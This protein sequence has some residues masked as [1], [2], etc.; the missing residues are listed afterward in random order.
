MWASD[1]VTVVN[2]LVQRF[3]DEQALIDW[4]YLHGSA[5]QELK[6]ANSLQGQA[7]A[8]VRHVESL[9]PGALASFAAGIEATTGQEELK[10]A[11]L[12]VLRRRLVRA[13]TMDDL[14]QRL[15]QWCL[16]WSPPV[17]AL[18]LF[19]VAVMVPGY[20]LQQRDRE[21]ILAPCTTYAKVGG[22][23]RACMKLLKTERG[24]VTIAGGVV[25]LA[26]S[27]DVLFADRGEFFR[28]AKL[29]DPDVELPDWETHPSVR[30]QFDATVVED[31][32]P[33]AEEALIVMGPIEGGALDD[34]MK[35]V[36]DVPIV[37][38]ADSMNLDARLGS[39]VL[40]SILLDA[41][42]AR[43]VLSKSGR[44]WSAFARASS[45]EPIIDMR[46]PPLRG[47]ET[48]VPSQVGEHINQAKALDAAAASARKGD[49][50]ASARDI[51]LARKS[52]GGD[53][54]IAAIIELSDELVALA[55]GR[56][57][58]AVEALK[59][60]QASE[61]PEAV[62]AHALGSLAWKQ[63]AGWS[64]S[65]DA[66]LYIP[67]SD[68]VERQRLLDKLSKERRDR[69]DS[70]SSA[71]DALVQ[72]RQEGTARLLPPTDATS[73]IEAK[74]DLNDK[75]LATLTTLA[76]E[77]ESVPEQVTRAIGLLREEGWHD[78]EL[79][80]T[81]AYV[82]VAPGTVAKDDLKDVFERVLRPE[83]G[84][85][86]STTS[87]ILFPAMV[88]RQERVLDASEWDAVLSRVIPS[89]T[90]TTK[91]ELKYAST[92]RLAMRLAMWLSVSQVAGKN[93]QLHKD[94]LDGLALSALNEGTWSTAKIG[95][96]LGT[97]LY[98][99]PA[100]TNFSGPGDVEQLM[101]WLEQF[102]S[103]Y[104]EQHPM[105]S[106]IANVILAFGDLVN[107]RV[108]ESHNR[109]AKALPVLR[110]GIPQDT[111]DRIWAI[112][113]ATTYLDAYVLAL[114]QQ[115]DEARRRL[116]EAKT[117]LDDKID[118]TEWSA[119]EEAKNYR[120]ANSSVHEMLGVIV[121]V[122][123]H[124]LT[125][126]AAFE[127]LVA[128]ANQT[129]FT[130]PA[131]G[132]VPELLLAGRVGVGYAIVLAA[133]LLG[134][135]D[136]PGALPLLQR[137]N[138]DLERV[139]GVFGAHGATAH[140]VVQRVVAL[141][142]L[143]TA[144]HLD[145]KLLDDLVEGAHL[146][147]TDIAPASLAANYS[148]D[149]DRFEGL[150]LYVMRLVADVYRERYFG[151]IEPDDVATIIRRRC[152]GAIEESFAAFGSHGLLG[153]A[154]QVTKANLHA[155]EG[156]AMA[157]RAAFSDASKTTI[158]N[159][160][161]LI[162]LMRTD[163][164]AS[165]GEDSGRALQV[166]DE[167]LERN[168]QWAA[169]LLV[170]R[171]QI[172]AGKQEYDAAQQDLRKARLELDSK[173][174]LSRFEAQISFNTTKV[175][176]A[177]SNESD[178]AAYTTHSS[179]AKVVYDMLG[180]VLDKGK[181]WYES[182]IG[183]G[184][185][186][187]AM[188]EPESDKSETEVKAS[189][190]PK[191]LVATALDLADTS[192]HLLSGEEKQASTT[193]G[194][195]LSGLDTAALRYRSSQ[196][197][198]RAFPVKLA[199]W[200]AALADL[201]GHQELASEL[202]ATAK[203][204]QSFGDEEKSLA[205]LFSEPP[206]LLRNVSG[207]NDEKA[208]LQSVAAYRMTPGDQP[209]RRQLLL[210]RVRTI[211]SERRLLQSWSVPLW[212]SRV[213]RR[214][215]PQERW[216][217]SDAKR[218]AP[219]EALIELGR[220]L[221]TDGASAPS[222]E[223]VGALLAAGYGDEV[224][225]VL[226]HAAQGDDG[227]V[228]RLTL[229]TLPRVTRPNRLAPSVMKLLYRRVRQA[230]FEI[231]LQT[232]RAL[233]R[234]QGG[235]A[236]LAAVGFRAHLLGALRTESYG[237]LTA[238]LE[239]TLRTER[240]SEE[241][242]F[243]KGIWHAVSRVLGEQPPE[244]HLDTSAPAEAKGY[245]VSLTRSYLDDKDGDARSA[246]KRHLA[247]VAQGLEAELR[248]STSGMGKDGRRELEA[249]IAAWDGV[250]D[251]ERRDSAR[252]SVAL[253][254]FQAEKLEAAM[255][256]FDVLLRG[257]Q[258]SA[259]REQVLRNMIAL[260]P[261]VPKY[262]KSL[263]S[264]FEQL[265]K[266]LSDRAARA[267]TV[268]YLIAWGNQLGREG[269]TEGA[270]ARF[271]DALSVAREQ[272]PARD[273]IATVLANYVEHA[274]PA[275]K[276]TSVLE[277]LIRQENQGR[278]PNYAVVEARARLH[279]AL[280]LIEEKELLRAE[281]VA[282][283]ARTSLL[284][285][286]DTGSAVN[287]H[288]LALRARLQRRPGD[289]DF[290][291]AQLE[292][293][294]TSAVPQLAVIT[295]Q[296]LMA[297]WAARGD[298]QRLADVLGDL[299]RNA[300]RLGDVAQVAEAYSHLSKTH[301]E[302]GEVGLARDEIAYL[303]DVVGGDMDLLLKVTNKLVAGTT[304]E[305]KTMVAEQFQRSGQSLPRWASAK[306]KATTLW[307]SGQIFGLIQQQEQ[308]IAA[309]RL[310]AE[311]ASSLDD[312]DIRLSID[313]SQFE[314]LIAS[315]SC[316]KSPEACQGAVGFAYRVLE[317]CESDGRQEC[318]FAFARELAKL[319]P[320]ADESNN[321]VKPIAQLYERFPTQPYIR[322]EYAATLL[323][324]L[325]YQELVQ[326]ANS[327]PSDNDCADVVFRAA[328][329]SAAALSS[330]EQKRFRADLLRAERKCETPL[331]WSFQP[332]LKRLQASVPTGDV[333]RVNNLFGLLTESNVQKRRTMLERLGRI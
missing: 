8:I 285:L 257:T 139:L 167:A 322:A 177:P 106:A 269:D 28:L 203:Y 170:A 82:T 132:S 244:L 270:K 134:L 290:L 329:W 23:L 87:L 176:R 250:G 112:N 218:D 143:L 109:L 101:Q 324:A 84:H 77:A 183:I 124:E 91:K 190:Y 130:E 205:K 145:A 102:Q 319:L 75:K 65:K 216:S 278:R 232:G 173:T 120:K 240:R 214:P 146:L 136:A 135:P 22:E 123:G 10:H 129:E 178:S 264:Y 279:L 36:D 225:S 18:A 198:L 50:L 286:K 86:V 21:R 327:T 144:E 247:K 29:L 141:V 260:A 32:I 185:T 303:L 1:R 267:E 299:R 280:A 305:Y 174:G 45:L 67:W 308:A 302:L 246:A 103:Q 249:V 328:A 147:I 104:A 4:Y 48:L 34:A 151:R 222:K 252:M 149:A 125:R 320:I 235:S 35:D 211:K 199:V 277:A 181:G 122:L 27:P 288:E 298:K 155:E 161:P 212:L 3:A 92:G 233:T 43:A 287:A 39:S 80:L 330:I 224:A 195:A 197:L 208:L 166:V 138:R 156:D 5:A 315:A 68:P 42:A 94:I 6:Q 253:I 241:R 245:Q 63:A 304:P 282:L 234:K 307:F 321:V 251:H 316:S 11:A 98:V 276:R 268:S 105:A 110:R 333:D 131:N 163:F 326:L 162:D 107:R 164:E 38:L 217:Q 57:G 55:A 271:M 14:R 220:Y 210:D 85:L 133:R 73:K 60:L 331:E 168:P 219:P 152:L 261:K 297:H 265:T 96:L 71:A 191:E 317:Q 301:F 284:T 31:R 117:L 295:L 59:R 25:R 238:L 100:V 309:L 46:L 41:T 239:R 113:L 281:E 154:L 47:G 126:P 266:A 259:L 17:V 314:Q 237:E 53:C 171:A 273:S 258:S 116:D 213:E 99:L 64:S 311:E 111:G 172:H 255:D 69:L 223:V 62:Y 15:K 108:S 263:G 231:V 159:A 12:A 209:F 157:A 76:Y 30:E 49:L 236:G 74:R 175:E 312:D 2:Y 158:S 243:L 19:G 58:A 296:R 228:D 274:L 24:N 207:I 66:E 292:V 44:Q 293:P 95:E 196:D 194:D 79:L 180:P 61:A 148:S 272:K 72:L 137:A 150:Q 294:E 318:S 323:G 33:N 300:A 186:T 193:L 204:A 115:A 89:W 188:P 187:G 88:A 229:E 310:A 70:L 153:T 16:R 127:R 114:D 189:I 262:E 275:A 81:S 182:S 40:A 289:T 325:R 201:H 26:L 93:G 56:A 202:F 242:Y 192:Y 313:M 248:E 83:N 256:G 332:L 184:Y 169:P 97:A 13:R 179:A 165:E 206:T 221:A 119:L 227:Q 78:A 90:L 20:F 128:I 7:V 142:G 283:A 215:P 118:K 200:T 306:Q 51:Q 9:G 226:N 52:C 254:D 140:R 291:Q 54:A 37:A 160:K 121:Q 230:D